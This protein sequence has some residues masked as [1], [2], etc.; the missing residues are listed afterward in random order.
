M[1]FKLI[2]LGLTLFT[3]ENV[4]SIKPTENEL[5]PTMASVNYSSTAGKY[6]R[7]P[8]SSGFAWVFYPLTMLLSN[9]RPAFILS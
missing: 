6:K 8:L 1:L 3:E 5:Q 2:I 9:D 4:T 7:F